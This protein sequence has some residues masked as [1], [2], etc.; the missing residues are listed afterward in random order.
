M[1]GGQRE[2]M[3]QFRHF[4][5]DSRA[6]VFVLRGYAGTGK[7]TLLRSFVD[8]V[9][10]QGALYSLAASTG[11]AAK[12]LR[13]RTGLEA[14]TLHSMIYTF[15]RYGKSISDLFDDEE[16]P[17]RADKVEEAADILSLFRV[18]KVSDED[19]EWSLRVYFI[20]EASMISDLETRGGALQFGSGNV[21]SDLFDYDPGG[22]FVFVGDDSQLPP[23]GQDYSPALEPDYIARRYDLEVMGYRLTEIVRQAEE[24]GIVRAAAEIRQ[25]YLDPPEAKWGTLPLVGYDDIELCADAKVLVQD[26]LDAIEDRDFS[27][28]AFIS[29]SNK[30]CAE[31]SLLARERL[32]FR[33]EVERGDLLLV[34]RND[35]LHDLANGDLVEVLDVGLGERQQRGGI[36]F[37]PVRVANMDDGEQSETLLAL[38]LLGQDHPSLSSDS[39]KALYKDFAIR[40]R[41]KGVKSSTRQF[42]QALM[43]DPYLNALQCRYG[44]ALTCHKAQGGEWDEVYI[45]IPV[46]LMKESKSESYR[47]AYTALTRAKRRAHV[48]KSFIIR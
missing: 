40:M 23:V 30:R 29:L 20:D 38:D 8:F 7:T 13:L 14:V 16:T 4:I 37:V 9:E 12:M 24:S 33:A 43:Q 42:S 19:L 1:T 32:G 28:T 39:Y 36:T 5:T 18:S 11:R 21:L 2:A 15:S 3:E 25:L 48:A 47:W 31:V 22:K 34:T 10:E 41:K 26:Y 17:K 45:D 46:W 6:S 27:Q 35:L 44:Y